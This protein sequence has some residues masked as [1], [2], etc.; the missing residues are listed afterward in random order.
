M[1][2]PLVYAMIVSVLLRIFYKYFFN[3]FNKRRSLWHNP[4]FHNSCQ[5]ADYT[6]HFLNIIPQDIPSAYKQSPVDFTR[7]RDLPFPK[8]LTFT[9]SLAASGTNQGVDTKSNQFFKNARRSGLWIDANAVHRSSV[10]KARSKVPWQIFPDILADAVHLAYQLWP[11][12][13]SQYLWHGMSVYALDGSKYNLPSNDEIRQTFDPHS[14]LHNDGKGHYPQCLV[15]TLYDVFRRLPIARTVVGNNSCEREQMKELLPFVPEKSVWMFDRGYPSYESILYL[16]QNYS[17]YFL[18]RSPGTSTFPAVEAFVKSGK[19]E[20][21]IWL[22]P[23]NTFK[24]KVSVEKRRKL[25]VIKIRIIRLV[26]PD[27]TVSVLLTNLFGKKQYACDEIIELYFRRWEV[28]SYYRDEKVTLEIEKFHSKTVNGILQELHAVM[29]MS[30][31]SRTLMALS[32][33]WF[34]SG[35]KELQFKNAILTLAS[36]AAFLV[37]DDPQRAAMIFEEIIVEMSRVKYYRPENPRA[38]QPRVNKKPVNKW[39][40]SKIKKTTA[41]C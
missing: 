26:S 35:K 41:K 22:T 1:K 4:C 25:K 5:L 2:H 34:F 15:S 27:G 8:L 29:I 14:G 24:R 28:E 32:S 40:Q 7:N 3:K 36:D 39:N 12:N 10:S 19:K 21:I 31:I 11:Q 38:P 37:P 23:S 16:Q 9:L 18:F 33:Q 20:A 17:G 13:D 30:V 6:E